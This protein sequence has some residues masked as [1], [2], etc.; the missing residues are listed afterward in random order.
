MKELLGKWTRNRKL[1]LPGQ[2]SL[3][4]L[5]SVPLKNNQHKEWKTASSTNIYFYDQVLHR[6]KF[7]FFLENMSKRQSLFKSQGKGEADIYRNIKT[8]SLHNV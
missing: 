4:N 3:Y 7:I 8:Q 2:V 1:E 6:Q 5:S